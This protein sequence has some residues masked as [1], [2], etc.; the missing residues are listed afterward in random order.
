MLK[1]FFNGSP[2]PT[3]VALFLEEAGIAYEPCPV[4]TRKGEQFGAAF[5]AIN[6]N[7]KVPAIVDGDVTVFDSNAILLY[8]AEKTG[9]FLPPATQRG[10]LLSWLMFV[11][12]GVGPFSGQAVHFRHH[13]T[14]KVSY[15]HN[16]Y[17]YEAAR[18]YGV[19][20]ARL[21]KR[22]YMVGDTY[23]IVD[24][25]VWGWARMLTFIL[26]DGAWD[27]FPNVKRLHDEIMARPAAVRAVALK[28]KHK[29]KAEMD[30]EA[31]ANMFKHLATKAA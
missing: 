12:T 29:F 8:L 25:D 20:D 10:D 9:K 7:G 17:Q 26:G 11:A 13:A 21:A 15:A 19:L 30:D 23:T 4:D 31:R 5:L 18:H 27:K 28:D 24:M 2:N 22:R 16:R 14:E 6:P 3:K 1:F